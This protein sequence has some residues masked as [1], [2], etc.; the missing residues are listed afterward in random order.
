MWLNE[1]WLLDY[2]QAVSRSAYQRQA[3]PAIVPVRRWSDDNTR[4]AARSTASTTAPAIRRSSIGGGAGRGMARHPAPAFKYIP[5]LVAFPAVD[6]RVSVHLREGRAG[7][8]MPGPMSTTAIG[9]LVGSGAGGITRRRLQRRASAVGGERGQLAR[10]QI[11]RG[12]GC[13]LPRRGRRHRRAHKRISLAVQAAGGAPGG[14]AGVTAPATRSPAATR[15][16]E[17][18]PKARP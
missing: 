10:G 12:R 16:S 15:R 11:R 6:H 18:S 2:I 1:F 3:I 7:A 13:R 4:A 9:F 14:V 17:T 5:V 8:P